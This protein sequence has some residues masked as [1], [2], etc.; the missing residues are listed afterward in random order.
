MTVA[1][2]RTR[3]RQLREETRTQILDA[4][5]AFLRE[6]SF[7]DLSVEGLMSRTGHTRTVFYRHFDDI[8]SLVL[9]L[10]QEVGA[11]MVEVA[12][13]WANTDVV[14]PDEARRRLAIFVEF[15]VRH[16]PV[17]HAVS[18]AAHHDETV[19]QAYDAMVE[20]FIALTARAIEARATSGAIAPVDAP[21]IARA[22]V[23]MLNGYLD[24]TLGRD[25]KTDPDRV[26]ETIST[27]WVRTLFPGA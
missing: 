10:I 4:A 18:E 5:Q 7:R 23:R 15:Y 9:T 2:Q 19:E 3:R 20:G 22:L 17:V 14:T 12:E 25:G 26:L 11:E 24:D 8:P 1:T 16:G 27:I 13:Q 21:E 6:Q